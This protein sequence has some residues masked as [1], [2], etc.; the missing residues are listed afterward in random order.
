AKD[1]RGEAR[2]LG[3]T[4]MPLAPG[5]ADAARDLYEQALAL[6]RACGNR[7][8]EGITLGN[9]GAIFRRSGRLDEARRLFD[10]ALAIYREL[11]DRAS[12][13]NTTGSLAGLLHEHERADEALSLDGRA[14]HLAR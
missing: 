2:P 9:L 6:H 3:W 12:E 4:A 1:A 13:A 8:F 5:N 14:L 11:G 10:R 7:R